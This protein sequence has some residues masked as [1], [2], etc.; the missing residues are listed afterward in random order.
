M[1]DLTSDLAPDPDATHD[2]VEE[3]EPGLEEPNARARFIDELLNQ[4]G[5]DF[6]MGAR[7]EFD[8]AKPAAFD[9]S[10][11]VEWASHRAGVGIPD[12]SWIQYQHLDEEGSTMEVE[13]ALATEGALLFWFSR[14]PIGDPERPRIAHVAVS[15]GDGRV[16]EAT[17]GR[18]DI[19][20]I[21]DHGGRF[22]HAGEVPGL[23]GI[24]LTSSQAI[25]LWD[26]ADR[27]AVDQDQDRIPDASEVEHGTDPGS[28]DSDNDGVSD[29]AAFQLNYFDESKDRSDLD[30]DRDGLL[31]AAELRLGT[32]PNAFDTDGDGLDDHLEIMTGLDPNEFNTS[33]FARS[34]E[35][36]SMG[37]YEQH[38][39]AFGVYTLNEHLQ[40]LRLE[41]DPTDPRVPDEFRQNFERFGR[42]PSVDDEAAFDEWHRRF[43]EATREAEA[44][45]L[46]IAAG[47]EGDGRPDDEAIGPPPGATD[48]RPAE[49]VDGPDFDLLDA[50][51]EV[52]ETDLLQPFD[53]FGP[54]PAPVGGLPTIEPVEIELPVDL[55]LL[56]PPADPAVDTDPA[57]DPIDPAGSGSDP[58][59]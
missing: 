29:L 30:A 46:E 57:V 32:D 34:D 35:G 41:V 20:R 48:Q 6:E 24:D 7:A 45:A 31:D 5:T 44:A 10:E 8:D 39:G 16:V 59:A 4:V 18:H 14:D 1:T 53:E 3:M 2:P 25:D 28:T 19:V 42:E 38:A 37:T 11:L 58:G 52:I 22:T 47:A 55:D 50:E 26:K 9:A 27:I 49:P 40:Y 54:D 13:E 51:L 21:A 56:G 17:P 33:I 36:Q 43:E 23:V 15:L 12:G